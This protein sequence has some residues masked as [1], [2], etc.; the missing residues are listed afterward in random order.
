[1]NR[2]R[3]TSI[4]ANPMLIGAVTVLVTIVAV[5]LSYNAN[6]GLPFV[7]TY[8]VDVVLPDA[9]GLVKGNEVRLGGD[10]A[11]IVKDIQAFARPDGSTRARLVLA[12]DESDQRLPIDTKVRVRPK[13][14]LGLKYVE[15]DTG[16]A[17]R[18]VPQGG[19]LTVPDSQAPPVEIDDFFN[20][21]DTPT[22]DGSTE[23]L[24][25]FGTGFAGRGSDLNKAFANLEPLVKH[26]DP[27]VRNLV[28]PKTQFAQLFPAFE[29]AAAEVAP[30]ADTQGELFANL[31]QTF[32]AL[33]GSAESL[34][35]TIAGGP[36]ALDVATHELPAQA[37]FERDSAELFRRLKAPFTS[38]AAASPHLASAFRAGTPALKISPQ[39]NA[40]V[41]KTLKS[42]ETFAG[43]P[44]VIPALQ[45]LT[46][47]ANLLDPTIA[48]ATPVQTTCNALTLLFRNLGSA[49]SESD[50][51]GSFLRFTLVNAVQDAPLP[52]QPFHPAG[53]EIGPAA[54]PA[55]GPNDIGLIKQDSYLHSNP[56]P[57]TDAP[58]QT[59][60]CESGNESYPDDHQVI[61]NV[62]GNQGTYVDPSKRELK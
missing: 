9:S 24:F 36:H 57:N 37:G 12:L 48:F 60:E 5:Y 20:M 21:F 4:A 39:L 53:S 38:L 46:R 32:G 8:Q 52:G 44:R 15:L 14:A 27:A 55:N 62:P 6:H 23:N 28:A 59:P 26:L 40:R 41:V 13:S 51:V 31:N 61:G 3:N 11:G 33:A 56:Y 25:A 19:T 45:R 54:V 43:D 29:Q 42:L 22:R 1:M 34:K 18:T 58:G 7:P 47:T 10:R 16:H 35:A 2:R 49:I 30:V 50:A 17:S